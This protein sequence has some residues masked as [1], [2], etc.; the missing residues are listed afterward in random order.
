MHHHPARLAGLLAAALGTTVAADTR[1]QDFLIRRAPPPFTGAVALNAV[2]YPDHSRLLVVRDSAGNERPVR[3]PADWAIRVQH[4]RANMQ[5]VMGRLPDAT[6]RVP[7]DVEI[8][9]E[10]RTARYVRRKIRY[11]PEPGDR[12]P[13]WL[14]VP[15]AAT[16]GNRAPALLC[17]HQTTKIGKDEPAGLAGRDSLHYAHEL[18]ERGYVCLAPDYPSFGEYPYDF[19]NQGAHHASGTIKGIWNHLRAVD[20]LTA[21]PEV[22]GER[23]GVI[24]HSLGGGNA[25]FVAAFDER[26]KAVVSSG[27]FT[28]FHDYKKGKLAPWSQDLYMPRIREIYDNSPDKVPFD[29]YEIVASLAPRGFFSNSPIHDRYCDIGGVRKAFAKAAEVYALFPAPTD[30]PDERLTLV[31]PDAPHDFPAAERAAAYAWLDR[32]LRRHNL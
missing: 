9:S 30:G 21:L 24:G 19:R 26:L 10:V 5:Q 8:V 1:E 18:A 13:A 22:D 12:V 31:T 7:L 3:T 17:L 2:A 25:L 15:H 27:G 20:L 23:I 11:S 6:R 16:A 29:F 4:L 32:Q 28:P 14:L